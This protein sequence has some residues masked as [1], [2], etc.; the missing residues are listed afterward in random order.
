M[1]KV[2]SL[3]LVLLLMGGS[4]ISTSAA[5]LNENN[6][7]GELEVSYDTGQNG[8]DNSYILTIPAAFSVSTAGVDKTVSA[9]SVQIENGK[10]LTVAIS[11]S[12]FN[13]GTAGYKMQY[14]S[15]YIPYSV[16]LNGVRITKSPS[17]ILSV[18]Y[19][20]TSGSAKLTF[21]TTTDWI[22]QA[23]QKGVHIDTMTFSCV[24]G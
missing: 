24:V 1:K 19:N 16:D 6:K 17:T 7:V 2:L 15:S 21:R 22:N 20:N 23:T 10:T 18:P 13:K 12:N 4:S 3:V 8:T 9:T 11:S 14:N 5:N